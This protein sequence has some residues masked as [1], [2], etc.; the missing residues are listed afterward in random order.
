MHHDTTRTL[1]HYK[2]KTRDPAQRAF[3][4]SG[5]SIDTFRQNLFNVWGPVQNEKAGPKVKN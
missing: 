1:T 4:A 2:T 3:L 5:G